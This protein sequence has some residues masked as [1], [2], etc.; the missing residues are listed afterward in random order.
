MIGRIE[1]LTAD[2]V[3]TQHV[4]TLATPGDGQHWVILE[5]GIIFDGTPPAADIT[6]TGLDAV[7][8]IPVLSGSG[9]KQFAAGANFFLGI[10]NTA[11]V[12]TVP[13]GGASVRSLVSVLAVKLLTANL[14]R[15][16][17]QS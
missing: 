13:A 2:G 10:E 5:L 17:F 4:I 3:N 16:Y 1:Y 11:V 15:L 7:T 8:E 6:I 9:D 12:V 14:E